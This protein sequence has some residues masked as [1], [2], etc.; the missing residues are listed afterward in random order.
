MSIVASLASTVPDISFSISFRR[1]GEGLHD[2]ER[3]LHML[4]WIELRQDTEMGVLTL[5][6]IW[7]CRNCEHL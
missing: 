7:L 3:L 4:L 6:I 2:L 5:H 1:L